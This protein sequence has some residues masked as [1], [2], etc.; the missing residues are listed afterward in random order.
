MT[1]NGLL[2]TVWGSQT[3]SDKLAD[4]ASIIVVMFGDLAG[5]QGPLSPVRN[6]PPFR[7]ARVGALVI[8][9]HGA[10]VSE[11]FR[12]VWPYDREF[13]Y[14]RAALLRKRPAHSLRVRTHLSRVP[15]PFAVAEPRG[16]LDLGGELAQLAQVINGGQTDAQRS[17]HLGR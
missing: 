11:R 15:S 7:T 16:S 12:M 4:A 3:P 17:G 9:T 5:C 6:G 14:V 13:K 8:S 10:P 1:S 2:L